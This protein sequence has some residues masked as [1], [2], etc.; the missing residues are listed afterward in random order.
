MGCWSGGVSELSAEKELLRYLWCKKGDFIKAW[1]QDPRAER[2]APGPNHEKTLELGE[3][4]S[5]G[6]F[7]SDFHTLKKTQAPGG[8]ATVQLRLFFPLA[9]HQH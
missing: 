3:V 6:S 7:Q 5:R 9:K 2:A 4:K 1:G 8:P